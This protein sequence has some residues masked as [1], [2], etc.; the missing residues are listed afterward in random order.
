M[1]FLPFN[2]L[3]LQLSRA[4]LRPHEVSPHPRLPVQFPRPQIL[5][6]P[7]PG[8]WPKDEILFAARWIFQHLGIAWT[9]TLGSGGHKHI[10]TR[11]AIVNHWETGAVMSR[12][13]TPTWSLAK[14]DPRGSVP[15]PHMTLTRRGISRR[16]VANRTSHIP[17]RAARNPTPQLS[18]L[19]LHATALV[20]SRL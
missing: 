9:I 8:V 1:N 17:S 6:S 10:R 19:L 5:Q 2:P 4:P 16:N 3:T 12:V 13:A 18:G 7:V 15:Q 20:N 11:L 14:S